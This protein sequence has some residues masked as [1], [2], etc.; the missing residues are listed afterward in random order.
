MISGSQGPWRI[1]HFFYLLKK[2]GIYPDLSGF[3]TS[4]D[5]SIL[6]S[7]FFAPSLDRE[8]LKFPRRA[9]FSF[10]DRKPL[11]VAFPGGQF[12]P[13]PEGK[14]KVVGMVKTHVGRA[15]AKSLVSYRVLFAVLAFHFFRHI[16]SFRF[17]F[18]DTF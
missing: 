2:T 11:K 3:S 7:R 18:I 4:I 5:E 17:L 1:S 10:R 13:G 6:Q 12:F 16:T 14:N 8:Y 15:A 9:F